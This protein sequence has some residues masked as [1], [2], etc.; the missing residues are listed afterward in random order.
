MNRAAPSVCFMENISG[1]KACEF[2]KQ[3]LY[4]LQLKK[5]M[6]NFILILTAL[7]RVL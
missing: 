6:L 1:W 2:L 4:S 3:A 7:K 5:L